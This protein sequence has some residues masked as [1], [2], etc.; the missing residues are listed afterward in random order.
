MKKTYYSLEST[1]ILQFSFF[2]IFNIRQK[3]N[4]RTKGKHI[5]FVVVS[6]IKLFISNIKVYGKWKISKT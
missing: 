3:K 4:L 5:Y 1:L 6:L 2:I